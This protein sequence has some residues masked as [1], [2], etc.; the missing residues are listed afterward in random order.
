MLDKVIIRL[1]E[2]THMTGLSKSTLAD[3]QNRKSPRFDPTFPIKVSLGPRAV[4]HFR[5]DVLA[6]LSSR[7]EVAQPGDRK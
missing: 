7:K 4:G 6:W 5:E 3:K 1:S 2:L